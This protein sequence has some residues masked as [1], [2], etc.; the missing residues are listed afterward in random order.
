MLLPILAAPRT[1][2]ANQ[3]LL[4]TDPAQLWQVKSGHVALFAVPFANGQPSG[5]RRFLFSV[6]AGEAL[7]AADI[8]PIT[9]LGL[10]AIAVEPAEIAPLPLSEIDATDCPTSHLKA[11]IDPWIHHW[12]TIDGFPKPAQTGQVPEI[13][14]I[15][16]T[17]GQ[18]CRPAAEVL[19][20]RMQRG[21]ATWMGNPAFPLTPELGCFPL[22]QGTYMQAQDH[23][24]F[25][26][27][28][29]AEVTSRKV[30]IRGLAQLHCYGFST[31]EQIDVR[32]QRLSLKRF[33]Q[34]QQLNQSVTEN[35]VHSLAGVLESDEID[36]T[37]SPLLAVA[38]AVGKAL[39]VTIQP[40]AA[41]ENGA[42]MKQPLDAIARA[43][44]LR[45]RRVLLRGEWWRQDCGPLVAYT[46]EG[47][48]PVAL[49][50]MAGPRYEIYAPVG[51]SLSPHSPTSPPPSPHHLPLT[52]TLA[53]HLDPVAFVFYRPLPTDNL[54]ALSLLRFAFRG[55]GRDWLMIGL[56]GI[57]ATLIGMVV[58]Q[59][60]AVLVDTVVPYGDR[61]LLWQIGLGL[62]AAAFGAASFQLAQ[63]IA[64]LRVET[65]AD[66][67]LQAAVWDRLLKL[68][69][70]F[71]RQYP[72]GDLASRVSSI[73][74]IR[75]KLSGSALQGLFAGTF[76]LLNLGLLI[77]YSP[78]LAGVALVVGL[79]VMA[80]TV[81]S[82][83]VLVR[84]YRPLLEIQ[85]QLYGLVVQLINGIAKL[86]MA[87]AEERAFAVWGQ[88]YSQQLRLT[89][90]TQQLEDAVAVFNTVLPIVTTMALFWLA[91]QMLSGADAEL[92]TGTFLAF[93]VAFGTFVAGATSLSDTLVD[94]LDVV[95]LWQRASPILQA[96]PEVNLNK[97]DPGQL[98]GLLSVDRVTFRYGDEGP[99]ILDNV[100]F[101]AKPGEFIALVGPS[102]S[103]KSTAMR[104]LLGFDTPQAGSV[105]YDGQALS[106]LD[107]VAVRRQCGVVLQTSRLSAGS[108]FENL[109]GGALITLDDAWDAA[110]K[111]GLAADLRAMPMQM[112]TVVSEGG[113][114]L[115]GG[116]RQRLLIARALAVKPKI[117][118]MDEATSAL[119]NRTQAIVTES[120]NRLKVTRVVIAHR[121]STIRHADRIYVLEAGRLVQQ[122]SFKELAGQPGLFSQL[123]KRQMT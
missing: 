121:L 44:Q 70:G 73:S 1:I 12:G 69:T 107:V 18:V 24:E 63:A 122:G 13:H 15:S 120:L 96:E 65:G 42:R 101:E 23:I 86:R 76:S 6:P 32:Q 48:S 82:G 46:K 54:N 59:A 14:Y 16:L 34:R 79:V 57:A 51:L 78:L 11:L 52:P 62:L 114:N 47:R 115:S 109:S 105:Y 45:L 94:L 40:Q 30:L 25:F 100:S 80:V 19:W 92:S 106:G 89:L 56:T 64:T 10:M 112:H 72:T 35:V 4:L 20:I 31:I 41:S 26:A 71:F 102:G 37:E 22:G 111:A 55:Q 66:A 49:L 50:P 7:F 75:R 98:S 104:L 85:G 28:P 83:L 81:A 60:T 39:G 2:T 29:T 91:S 103:G 74:T 3:P 68:K 118:L 97:A 123:I 21:T 113:S 108:I 117:M 67:H 33:Q 90:S 84:R 119:D 116:Q 53:A 5:K 77:Y 87:G 95:P 8:C 61:A 27:R 99:V 36:S 17:R 93:S 88:R 58:P 38:G 9:H 110:E 43:S